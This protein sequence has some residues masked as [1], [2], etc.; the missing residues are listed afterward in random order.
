MMETILAKSLVSTATSIMTSPAM[1]KVLDKACEKLGELV[2]Q[3]TW[4][5]GCGWLKKISPEIRQQTIIAMQQYV[6]TYAERH[7]QIKVLGMRQAVPLEQIFTNVQ[8]LGQEGLQIFESLETLETNY[9]QARRRRFQ[10]EKNPQQDGLTVANQQQFLMVL[11]Q[12]GA[13][14]STFL[15]RMGWEAL[16]VDDGQYAYPCIP[17][18]VELKRFTPEIGLERVIEQELETCGF[19]KPA[20]LSQQLLNQG[21]LLILLD[22]LDEVPAEYQDQA[23][24]QIQDF[25]DRYD[26]NRF[27][28]S[29]RT[30]AYHASFQRF[31]DV[32]MAD[33]DDEQIRQFIHNWFHDP[34]DQRLGTAERCWHL[35]QLPEYKAAKELAQTPLLLTLLCL[36]FED[37]QVFPQKRAVLYGHALEVLLKTWAAEKRIQRKPI[38]KD[39][40]I[41]LEQMMLGEIAHTHFQ[42]DQLFFPE[43]DVTD[44]IHEFLTSNLNAPNHLDAQ[45]VLEA[46]QTQQGILVE[47]A[48]GVLSFSH[49]TLQE[50]LTAQFIADNQAISPLVTNH[51]L[52]PRWR[53]VFQL[54][55]GL[56]RVRADDLLRQMHQQITTQ[57]GLNTPRLQHLLKWAQQATQTAAT[58]PTTPKF[59]PGLQAA[60]ALMVTFDFAIG[61]W[62]SLVNRYRQLALAWDSDT[63]IEQSKVLSRE[64]DLARTLTRTEA[65][66]LEPIRRLDLIINLALER[67]SRLQALEILHPQRLEAFIVRLGSL[68]QRMAADP[69]I[70]QH[71]EKWVQQIPAMWFTSFGI[72]PDWL[73]L[74][75]PECQTLSNYLSATELLVRCKDA[76]VRVMPQTWQTIAP[77]ILRPSPPVRLAQP[78]RLTSEISDITAKVG[79]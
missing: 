43:R 16:K 52:D 63:T 36:V 41:P 50:Y 27:I 39:L 12:P 25:V 40:S 28:A 5:Q 53:E 23:I 79:A 60:I 34:E 24:T 64:L 42:T 22:G 2:I 55:A 7:G 8:F 6:K 61:E 65:V 45:L 29:C 62:G 49:L 15:K 17:V 68:K 33:F 11:G 18:F 32:V 31:R 26:R 30:A 51:L 75:T 21:K 10:W 14:K 73:N 1:A 37:S 70:E 44:Q 38:Y 59:E 58:S 76:A 3:A 46:I 66:E 69:H 78:Q 54:V 74:S 77:H 20:D 72:D 13:G 48:R 4:N 67:A 47:R 57:I 35:L 71:Y 56:M 9:R 19:P